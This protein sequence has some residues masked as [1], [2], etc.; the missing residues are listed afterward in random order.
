MKKL[1]EMGVYSKVPRCSARQRGCEVIQTRFLDQ[2]RLNGFSRTV[3]D[4]DTS[5]PD[6][7]ALLMR[8]REAVLPGV[9]NLVKLIGDAEA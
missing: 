8:M 9:M 5:D 1:V 7:V 6:N 3:R 4:V 2:N